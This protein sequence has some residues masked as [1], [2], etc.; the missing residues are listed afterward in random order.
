MYLNHLEADTMDSAPNK[1]QAADAGK[2]ARGAYYTLHNPFDHP[3]FIEW[4]DAAA[5]SEAQVLEPFAGENSLIDHLQSMGLAK[6]FA[7]FDITP[8]A[9]PVRRR[10]TLA[11]F[12]KGYGVCITNPPWLA[13]NS[14]TVRGL[15]YP[16]CGYDDIYKWSLDLCLAHC[17]WVAALIPESFIRSGLFHDRLTHFISIRKRLFS[18]TAHPVGLALFAPQ[19]CADG[20]DFRVWSGARPLGRWQDLCRRWLAPPRKPGRHL[21]FND[22]AGIDNVRHASIRFCTVKEIADYEIKQTSRFIT[23]IRAPG[24]PSISKLNDCL[25]EFRHQTGDIFLSAYR[26][27]RYDGYYR[28]RMDWRIARTVV[29]HAR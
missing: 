23:R 27:L 21:V 11:D 16:D 15:P 26:G 4:A 6:R 10:D 17:R 3:A 24:L 5:L 14:A 7:A 25:K 2:R 22:P 20:K 28:R 19:E 12:P 18:E 13:K 9:K 1:A 8:A 29:D